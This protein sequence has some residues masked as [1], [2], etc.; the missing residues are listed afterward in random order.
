MKTF[1]T[2]VGAIASISLFVALGGLY[3][4]RLQ[5]RINQLEKKINIIKDNDNRKEELTNDLTSI[6]S[7][8]GNTLSELR[9][10]SKSLSELSS[11]IENSD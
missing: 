11:R 8:P 5:D 10:K 3:I 4:L 7:L 1:F 2:W 6:K 9:A